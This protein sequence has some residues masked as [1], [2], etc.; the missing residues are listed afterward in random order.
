[1]AQWGPVSTRRFV[2]VDRGAIEYERLAGGGM[3]VGS[4]PLVFLH[5]G[6]GSIDL[7]R[8]VPDDVRSRLGDRDVLVYAR[9]GHGRSAAAHLPRPVTYM[10]HE[11]DVV[12]PALLAVLDIERPWLIGHSDGASIALLHAGADHDVAGIVC[13][14]PHVFVEPES[15]AGIAAARD[16]F[17]ATDMGARMRKYHADPEQTFRGWNDVWLSPPFSEW[18]IEDR[19]PAIE[20]PVL[21]VQGTDDQ[22]GTFAQLDAIERGVSGPVEQRRIVGAGHSPHLDARDAVVTVIVDFIA[23]HDPERPLEPIDV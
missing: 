20:A 4:S 19:L 10:H 7:W 17:D 18:N 5:E 15:I 2:D 23:R 16:Q 11:A 3:G 8:G 9:H 6:L 12:L 22:Y 13:L 14:A 21:L 1:V